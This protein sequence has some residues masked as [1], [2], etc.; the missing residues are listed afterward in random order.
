MPIGKNSLKR[1]TGAKV[2]APKEEKSAVAVAEAP[3][4]EEKSAPKKAPAKKAE[5]KK[6]EAIKA[7]PKKAEVIKAE[8]IKAEAKKEVAK[9]APAKKA[10]PKK[11]MESEPSFSPVKTAEKVIAKPAN[12]P[13]RQGEGYVNLGG[14]LPYYLL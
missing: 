2:D 3:K 13:A 4:L 1:V 11:S 14:E 5:P 12:T 8:P 10:S 7:E 9:K 6:A